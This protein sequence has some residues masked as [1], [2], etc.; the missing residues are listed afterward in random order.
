MN[1]P[2]KM[3]IG[4][5][6]FVSWFTLLSLPIQS[7]LSELEMQVQA[8]RA[9][10]LKLLKE[11]DTEIQKLKDELQTRGHSDYSRAMSRQLSG[12]R[13]QSDSEERRSLSLSV[14]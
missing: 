14:S 9:R 2:W 5:T 1:V 11:K 7:K 3:I 10:T 13:S 12:G 8:T 4:F 6:V